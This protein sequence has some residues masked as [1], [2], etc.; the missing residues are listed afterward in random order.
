MKQHQCFCVFGCRF[1]VGSF[2]IQTVIKSV[3]S[4]FSTQAHLY[5]VCFF[6]LILHICTVAYLRACAIVYWETL[7]VHRMHYVC[8]VKSDLFVCGE[9][10]GFLLQSEGAWRSD[11]ERAGSFRNHQTEPALDGYEP[12]HTQ[13]MALTGAPSSLRPTNMQSRCVVKT[14]AV[15]AL[16]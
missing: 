14:T 15:F 11:E 13:K 7:I 1:P 4:Q 9:G 8:C 2:A 16:L 5:Q 6:I 10:E 12:A 3:T